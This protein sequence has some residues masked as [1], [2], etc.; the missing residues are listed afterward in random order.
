VPVDLRGESERAFRG[1]T[2]TWRRAATWRRTLA[3]VIGHRL[4]PDQPT[5]DAAVVDRRRE[6]GGRGRYAGRSALDG[7]L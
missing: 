2:L 6:P 3:G 7:R 1:C 5:G 4:T